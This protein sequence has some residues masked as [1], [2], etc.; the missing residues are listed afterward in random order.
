MCT[1]W[2]IHRTGNIQ[3]EKCTEREMYRVRNVRNEK[4]TELEIYI[5]GCVQSEKYSLLKINRVRNIKNGQVQSDTYSH[6]EAWRLEIMHVF[7]KSVTFPETCYFS[8]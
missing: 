5:T 7:R 8:V 2:E 6:S 1:E 3:N 4:C